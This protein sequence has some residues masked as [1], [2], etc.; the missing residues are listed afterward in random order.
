M[1][2]KGVVYDAGC[3]WVPN[4][5]PDYAPALV[6]R[7]LEIIKTGLH[8]NFV[9]PRVKT[10]LKRD[11]ELQAAWSSPVPTADTAPRTR[12]WRGS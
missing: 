2:R 8:C 3:G 10:I 7:E 6:H 9:R 4:L 5:R 12:T 11:E 1:N